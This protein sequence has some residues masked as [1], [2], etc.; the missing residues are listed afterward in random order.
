MRQFVTEGLLLATAGCAAGCLVAYWIVMLMTRMIP[1]DV[2]PR[3]PFLS[4]VGLNAHTSAF[5]ALIAL[6]AAV[7]LAATPILRL[8]FQDIRDGLDEGARGAAGRLWRRM[9]ANL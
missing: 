5:A 7:L 8:S 2:A 6:L 3:V 4:G 9:G 1:K